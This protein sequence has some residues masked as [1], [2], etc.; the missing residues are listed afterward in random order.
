MANPIVKCP[1]CGHQF[2]DGKSA[3][4]ELS[5]LSTPFR[6]TGMGLTDTEALG[7]QSLAGMLAKRHT[8]HSCG[9]RF[10]KK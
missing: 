5:K 4:E 7:M 8:C 1:H 6:M 2:K 3:D 10:S 9:Q